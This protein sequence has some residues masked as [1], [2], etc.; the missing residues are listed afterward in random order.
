MAG[1]EI[2]PLNEGFDCMDFPVIHM[3]TFENALMEAS[4]ASIFGVNFNNAMF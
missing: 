2:Q 4:K 1:I 3:S